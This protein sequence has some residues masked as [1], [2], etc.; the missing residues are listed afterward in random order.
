M[1]ITTKHKIGTRTINIKSPARRIEFM[2]G[3]EFGMLSKGCKNFGICRIQIINKKEI[4]KPNNKFD[5]LESMA[6]VHV[7]PKGKTEIFFLNK[8]MEEKIQKLYFSKQNFIV[9]EDIIFNAPARC[10]KER[11]RKG[12][13]NKGAYPIEKRPWGY[14]VKF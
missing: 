7:G 11:D 4:L 3:I 14:W 10:P 8:G 9:G 12:F 5:N 6:L 1:T 13:I 2:A